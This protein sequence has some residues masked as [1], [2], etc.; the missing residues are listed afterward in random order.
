MRINFTAALMPVLGLYLAARI[1][2]AAADNPL[3]HDTEYD[4]DPPV[5]GS[6]DLPIIKLAP[7]GAIVDST[8]QALKLRELTH[9]RVTV[10][11][12]VY[13]RCAAPK[14]CPYATGVLYDLHA[15]SA[16]D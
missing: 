9:G 3:P 1:V 15:L 10:L 6:Y 2:S 5:P 7:D 16:D 8:G 13:T 4:Y 12:F 11:S 14:A